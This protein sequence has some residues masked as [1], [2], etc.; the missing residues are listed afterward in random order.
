MQAKAIG[1]LPNA[2]ASPVRGKGRPAIGDSARPSG[3]IE[4]V[5]PETLRRYADRPLPRYTSYPTAPH[6]API[7]EEVYRD[8]KLEP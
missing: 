7:G 3:R 1:T 6:F 5:T 4:E 2:S 8:E